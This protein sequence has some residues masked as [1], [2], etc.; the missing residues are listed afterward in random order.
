MP[1]KRVI[2]IIFLALLAPGAYLR[3]AEPI[4]LKTDLARENI[5]GQMDYVIDKDKKLTVEQIHTDTALKWE[6]PKK[7]S[8][9]FGYSTAAFW[10]RLTVDNP[11]QEAREWYLEL[12]Y[13]NLDRVELFMPNKEGSFT[14]K[15]SGDQYPM[16]IREL[17]YRNPLFTFIESPGSHTYYVRVE[18]TGSI[19][20]SFIMWSPRSF[21]NTAM[22]EMPFLWI[23][24]GV[25][26]IMIL[27]NLFLFI[28]VREKS[29]L[30]YV[31]YILAYTLMQFSLD[32]LSYQYLW[33]GNGWLT[34]KAI[35]VLLALA[36][37]LHIRFYRFYIETKTLYPAYDKILLF[38][39][40]LPAYALSAASFFMD[41]GTMVRVMALFSPGVNILSIIVIIILAFRKSRPARVILI[42][43]ILFV[44]GTVI[45]SLRSFGILPANLFTNWSL[46]LFSSISVVF[47]SLGLADKIN[48]LKRDLERTNESL[49]K[50]EKKAKERAEFLQGIVE[51]ITRTST[52]L[53]TVGTELD[54]I[55]G[56]LSKMSLEEAADT[57]EMASSF[58]ELTSATETIT[59]STMEQMKEAD[60]TQELIVLLQEAQKKLYEGNQSVIDNM[61]VIS[62]AA[63]RTEKNL[64]DMIEKMN[65]IRGG[66]TSI[67]NFISLID[68]ISDRINLLSLNAAIEAARAGDA[69]KGFAVVADEIGKLADA[70]STNSKE[71]SKE[72]SKITRDIDEGMDIVEETK[73]STESVLNMTGSINVQTEKVAGLMKNQAEALVNVIR[74]AEFIDQMSKEIASAS[75]EQTNSMEQ[76]T[77]T[78]TKLSDMSQE[79]A[80]HN[81]KVVDLTKTVGE[82]SAS[83]DNIVKRAISV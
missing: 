11:S 5:T 43:F 64:K 23:F 58:E 46:Q 67:R 80:Q 73:N 26:I 20:F 52:E 6:E 53:V 7:R 4:Q 71:I 15:L 74:Q 12:T 19:N 25:M 66:G 2:T 75:R 54:T 41:V 44:A 34:N 69:G 37:G 3:A 82:K 51:T 57:Q 83:L 14:T 49:L 18:S 56:K 61:A 9:N 13:P 32:G 21:T 24:Y 31:T 65:V 47:L 40:E 30:Y 22:D 29:Y 78:I 76:M 39:F 70:T 72:I 27:Y 8:A 33:S 77:E 1:A 45:Y 81:E 50:N 48:F 55:G 16:S 35:P 42:A 63:E 59:A 28:S 10:F 36:A 17:D 79:L 68:D 38:V 60:K 62:Q